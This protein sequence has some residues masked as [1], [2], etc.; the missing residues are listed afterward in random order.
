MSDHHDELT[1]ALSD[2]F[3]LDTS[4]VGTANVLADRSPGETR[5]SVD[6]PHRL[7]SDSARLTGQ[8]WPRP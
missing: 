3:G 2:V 8:E 4:T 7:N 5:E 1:A 6:T